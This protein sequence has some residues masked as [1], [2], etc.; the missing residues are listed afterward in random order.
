MVV[1]QKIDELLALRASEWFELLPTAS[2]AQLRELEAWLSESKLHVQ[3][4]LEIAEVEFALGGL[5]RQRQHDVEALLARVSPKVVPMPSRAIA[6]ESARV[7][8]WRPSWKVVAMAASWATLALLITLTMW[9]PTSSSKQAFTTQVGEHRIVQLADQSTVTMNADSH[10]DVTFGKSAREI[11]LVQGEATFEVAHDTTRPFRV[12]TRAGVV[13]AVGTK[14]N[15]RNLANGDTRVSLLE[16]RVRISSA[17]S[18]EMMMNAGQEVDIH[19]DGSFEPRANAVV[20]NAVSWQ[21]NRLVFENAPLA[22]MVAEFNRQNSTS[23]LRLDGVDG[24]SHRL[25]GVFDATD[26][27]ALA[28]LLARE[29]DL[30]VDHEGPVIVIRPKRRH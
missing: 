18:Q 22:E 28:E 29:P 30:T 26:P 21:A 27:E 12:H 5:D 23:Q 6:A 1:Q 4:F 8:A 2:A 20:S 7:R 14:F 13:Q 10:I 24:N 17:G 16:G 25:D 15:V 3:E 11:E 9:S 19:L